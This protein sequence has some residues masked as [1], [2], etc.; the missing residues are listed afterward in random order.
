MQDDTR[1]YPGSG[2]ESPTSSGGR[3]FL[4]YLHLSAC[5]RA[6]TSSVSVDRNPDSCLCVD[7]CL[8]FLLNEGPSVLFYSARGGQGYMKVLQVLGRMVPY[9]EKGR[10]PVLSGPLEPM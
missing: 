8:V 10:N 4:Y 5:T 9:T 7:S 6:N 2:K 3:R 1:I